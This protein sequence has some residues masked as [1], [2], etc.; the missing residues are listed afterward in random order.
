MAATILTGVASMPQRDCGAGAGR[1][2]QQD[3]VPAR[4][5]IARSNYTTSCYKDKVTG[6][7][8]GQCSAVRPAS[9]CF[10]HWVSAALLQSTDRR[11]NVVQP[12]MQ[13]A[14]RYPYP[15]AA[16]RVTDPVSPHHIPPA[17]TVPDASNR[18]ARYGARN[19]TVEHLLACNK[20][21]YIRS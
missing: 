6:G 14:H 18:C 12:S 9:F 1:Y 10:N 3:V 21:E 13:D 4:A 17:Y 8:V 16:T 2:L 19:A 11:M 20:S 15:F 5:A 7:S